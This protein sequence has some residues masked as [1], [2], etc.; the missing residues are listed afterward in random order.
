MMAPSPPPS[1]YTSLRS[2]RKEIRLLSICRTGD[3]T[4]LIECAFQTFELSTAPPF[5][6][7]SYVWGD[8]KV[9]AEIKV[10]GISTQITTN[11]FAALKRLRE[12]TDV[13]W[14]WAD[15]LCINQKDIA[16]KNHQV[17]LMRHIY[18]RAD[19]VL[20]WLGEGG[21]DTHLAFALIER[22]AEA[23]LS[24]SPDLRSWPNGEAMRAAAATVERPFDEQAWAAIWSLFRKTYWQRIWIVQEVFLARQCLM[25]CGENEILFHK[26]LWTYRAWLSGDLRLARLEELLKIGTYPDYFYP[27]MRIILELDLAGASRYNTAEKDAKPPARHVLSSLPILLKRASGL[28]ATDPR[29]K[30]YGVLGLLNVENL[31]IPVDYGRSVANAYTNVVWSVIQMTSRLDILTFG[32]I[33]TFAGLYNHARHDLPS[34]MPDFREQDFDT[35]FCDH[36]EFY[37]TFFFHA[38]K[39]TNAE[40]TI[41]SDLR[42]IRIKGMMC[43]EI[44]AVAAPSLDA[45]V[46]LRRWLVFAL[47][48]QDSLN[49]SYASAQQTL[50][51]TIICDHLWRGFESP[52]FLANHLELEFFRMAVGFLSA[53]RFIHEDRALLHFGPRIDSEPRAEMD[54]ETRRKLATWFQYP[55][56]QD[57]DNTNPRKAALIENFLGPRRSRGHLRWPEN[58]EFNS[59]EDHATLLW[60]R[61]VFGNT[62]SR[63]LFVTRTGYMGVGPWNAQAGDK[64]FLPLGCSVPLIV[65]SAGLDNFKLVGD[66]YVCG[67]MQGEMVQKLESGLFDLESVTI[68]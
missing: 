45:E 5:D 18:R 28:S 66:T 46:R 10:G 20:S 16:E 57:E 33:G 58:V 49:P 24:T 32:G 64:I 8:P 2:E 30:I 38:S 54:P 42:R 14:V 17:L 39:E 44:A 3:P 53:V 52:E 67:M 21:K 37:D 51:R 41:S 48:Q 9:T 4:A 22:W 15:A 62:D 23:I 31:P 43:D 19:R 63:C 36:T 27:F 6:S 35:R 1:V 25:I 60:F 26:I 50:F 40:C 29:D 11:L 55:T 59:K 13:Q 68:E 61:P 56:W 65:R 47:A 12:K 7:L 34:W